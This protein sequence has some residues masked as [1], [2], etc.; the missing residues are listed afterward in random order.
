VTL[1]ALALSITMP[2]AHAVERG[3]GSA[4]LLFEGVDDQLG[5]AASLGDIDGDGN[6]DIVLGGPMIDAGGYTNNGAVYLILGPDSGGLTPTDASATITGAA[7]SY[8]IGSALHAGG[9]FNG[10]GKDDLLI[11]ASGDDTGGTNAGRAYL[12]YGPVTGALTTA[13]ADATFTG[14]AAG[15]K[16]GWAV[17]SIDVDGDGN[18]DVVISAPYYSSSR[19]RVY[20][21]EGGSL[22]GSK[23]ASS[24][25][26]TFTGKS[27]SGEEAGY[28]LT[29]GEFG[30]GGASLVIAGPARDAGSTDNGVLYFLHADGSFPT[31]G[32]LDSVA[33]YDI[34]GDST[35]TRMGQHLA[36]GFNSDIS[37][38]QELLACNDNGDCP[39]FYDPLAA[40]T[41]ADCE[42]LFRYSGGYE[43]E[44]RV[45]NAGDVDGDGAGDFL[46]SDAESD[47]DGDSD[48]EGG[49]YLFYGA[50][51]AFSGDVLIETDADVVF[52]GTDDLDQFGDQ[53]SS[54][55]VNNDGKSDVLVTAPY[56]DL[57]SGSNQGAGYLFYGPFDPIAGII[58]LVD[59]DAVIDG[60][61]ANDWSGYTVAGL[62][63]IN[64][65]GVDDFATGGIF[66]DESATATGAV[67]IYFGPTPESDYLAWL[68]T[69][70]AGADADAIFYGD[71]ANDFAGNNIAGVGDL[72]DD[73]CGDF[74]IAAAGN[75]GAGADAGAVY[76]F[77]GTGALAASLDST[78]ADA[79]FEG[80]AAGDGF[81][82]GLRGGGDFDGDGIDDMVIGAPNNDGAASNAGAAYVFLGASGGAAWTGTNAATDAECTYRGA[83]A[84]E[85]AGWSL[86]TDFDDDGDADLAI[87]SPGVDDIL[88]SNTGLV[89][90]FYHTACS[91]TA[92]LTTADAKVR[93]K[94]ATEQFGFALAAG[95]VDNDGYDDLVVGAP[96]RDDEG[97]VYWIPGRASFTGF[98]RA[99]A[100][101][102]N[103]GSDLG[104]RF[105]WAVDAG[106]VDAEA[107]AEI[108]AGAPWFSV[109]ETRRG[110]GYVWYGATIAAWENDGLTHSPSSAEVKLVGEDA[111]D[112]AGWS[113]AGVGDLNQDGEED[114]GI[115]AYGSERGLTNQGAAYVV[116]SS[117]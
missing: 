74:A 75:D 41:V 23:A 62:G 114:I 60:D 18:D 107:G 65:D 8:E 25:D 52:E 53:I 67:Y 26:Y 54:G 12:Y 70:L 66:A 48:S 82:T 103:L 28:A 108:I 32:S 11:G 91:G 30:A 29:V 46:L 105:G 86:A 59:A 68:N 58:D 97:S 76:V 102:V 51:G 93:G 100:S 39:F 45:A 42:A 9:D 22:T 27:G 89:A 1:L 109:G 10:D 79:I 69:F 2:G 33:D 24:A 94:Y 64:C 15:D 55:D 83:A 44:L 21:W 49:A 92:S 57:V 13:S 20:I 56:Y 72:D 5:Q 117:H 16:L 84:N 96:Y 106:N 101:G 71:A 110:Q 85:W 87:G 95:D 4:D 80:A 112:F 43:P 104:Y 113:I 98:Y 47:Y 61:D 37:G 19:G 14:G 17:S 90:I 81:G 7:S 116:L 88:G 111:Y 99:P 34:L 63:D 6:S 115:G 38:D 3:A 73:G 78:D 35:I 50:S 77:Y 36:S 40:S 31:T